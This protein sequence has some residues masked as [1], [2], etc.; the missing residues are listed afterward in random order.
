METSTSFLKYKYPEVKHAADILANF[1]LT[2][3]LCQPHLIACVNISELSAVAW[4]CV[5]TGLDAKSPRGRARPPT[6]K[7]KKGRKKRPEVW[8]TLPI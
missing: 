5:A 1:T 8:G 3:C 7:R 6:Q 2:L 4:A